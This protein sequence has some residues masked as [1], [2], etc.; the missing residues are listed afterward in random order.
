MIN[1]SL[2]CSIGRST[3]HFAISYMRKN[4]YIF[5]YVRLIHFTVY[6]KVIYRGKLTVIH[7]IKLKKKPSY[8]VSGDVHSCN[9]HGK[10]YGSSSKKEELIKI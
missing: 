5:L 4:G 6:L 8:T 3:Q 1:K 2:L 10:Q 7:N 9:H